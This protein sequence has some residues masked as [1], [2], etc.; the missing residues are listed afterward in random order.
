[1]KKIRTVGPIITNVS[2]LKDSASFFKQYDNLLCICQDCGKEFIMSVKSARKI[3]KQKVLCRACNISDTKTNITEELKHEINEKRKKTNLKKFGVETPLVTER[4]RMSLSRIDVSEK[5]KKIETTKLERYGQAHYNNREKARNTMNEKYGCHS[6]CVDE[7][8][9]KKESTC[10]K[11]YGHT[12]SLMNDA[13]KQKSRQTKLEKYGDENYNNP[14]KRKLTCKNRYGVENPMQNESI[15]EKSV[16]NKAQ[17]LNYSIGYLY[18]GIHFDS[19]W[20]LAYYIWLKDN[21]KSF[22]YH[23]N[24]SIKYVD[25]YGVDREYFPDFLIEGTFVEIKGCQFFDKEGNP[26]N[27]YKKETWNNKYRLLLENNVQI[28]RQEKINEYLKYIKIKYGKGYLKK[29]KII[30]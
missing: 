30:K 8:K 18:Q 12:S 25:D 5:V 19:S 16:N 13:V 2:E 10:L 20:E 22:I 11:K 9:D 28:L 17:S 29:F 3:K 23:P 24:F 15:K 4:S 26:Y 14:E 7:I 6:S 1:M 21:N 27:P